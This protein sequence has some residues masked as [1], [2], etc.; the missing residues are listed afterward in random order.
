MAEKEK[1][2]MRRIFLIVMIAFYI[3]SLAMFG[4]SG[5]WVEW[6]IPML[7]VGAVIGVGEIVSKKLYGRTMSSRL[8]DKLRASDKETPIYLALTFLAVGIA[9]LI[10]HL[11]IV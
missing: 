9:A 1:S 3:A 11:V 2:L 6:F 4:I 5:L 7:G 8:G 10:A